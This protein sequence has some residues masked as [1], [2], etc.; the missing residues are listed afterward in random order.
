[1]GD[2]VMTAILVVNGQPVAHTTENRGELYQ[3][4]LDNYGPLCEENWVS[5]VSSLD[6][7]YSW[8]DTHAG[9]DAPCIG[10]RRKENPEE[11]FDFYILIDPWYIFE[12]YDRDERAAIEAYCKEHGLEAY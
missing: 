8:C 7:L 2:Y 10:F 9:V 6:E 1:M 12:I 4:L 3:Y 11:L 5:H